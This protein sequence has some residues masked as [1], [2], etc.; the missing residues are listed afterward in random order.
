LRGLGGAND[1]LASPRLTMMNWLKDSLVEGFPSGQTFYDLRG[2]VRIAWPG[3]I[4]QAELAPANT[5]DIQMALH[6]LERAKG[7]SLADRNYWSP[8]LF[9]RLRK[10][11]IGSGWT[12]S[13]H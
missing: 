7:I 5:S 12:L 6:V 10:K 13:G 9:E 4:M 1:W 2:H 11:G 3:V 8:R